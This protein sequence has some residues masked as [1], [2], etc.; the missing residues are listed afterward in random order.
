[1]IVEPCFTADLARQAGGIVMDIY[2]RGELGLRVK[3]DRTLVTEA[4]L[5]ADRFIAGQIQQ[6]DPT[7][8]LLSEEHQTTSP[9]GAVEGSLWVIDPVDGTANFS[10]GLP[11]WGVS[12]A[13]LEKG[14]PQEAALYYPALDELYTARLGQGAYLNGAPIQ[15][16]PPD[17]ALP[18]AFF[19]CCSRTYRQYQVRVPYKARILGCASYSLC[20]V[21]RG[22]AVLGF[23]VTPRLWD[24]AAAWLLVQE[25]GGIIETYDGAQP[26]PVVPGKEYAAQTYPTLAAATPELARKARQWIQPRQGTSV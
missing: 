26:F 10:L 7:A 25:A 2:R 3:T 4:D 13:R 9:A 20:A 12:V 5:A 15:A 18:S 6:H 19:S 17:P 24:I 22:M 14:S 1:M 21:A 23:E 11:H 16:K 8:R